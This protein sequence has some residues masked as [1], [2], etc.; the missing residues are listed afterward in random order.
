[1]A[2]KD[3][4]QSPGAIYKTDNVWTA[5]PGPDEILMRGDSIYGWFFYHADKQG[6][7]N[8][9]VDLS[10][11]VAEKYT[12]DAFGRPTILSANNTQ[13]SSSAVGN[14]FMFT[15]R[16]WLGELQLYD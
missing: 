7:V 15:G 10:G 13:L 11:H 2:R 16:E 4:I 6:S 8:A 14:R 12:Y 5:R 3:R 1:M 9:L